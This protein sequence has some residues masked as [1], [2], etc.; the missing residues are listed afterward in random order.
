MKKFPALCLAAFIILTLNS[1]AQD[2]SVGGSGFQ[3][4]QPAAQKRTDNASAAERT[5]VPGTLYYINLKD[6]ETP[7]LKGLKLIGNR[8][9]L[10]SDSLGATVNA[11]DYS[12]DNIR[13][14]FELNEWIE[15]WPNREDAP[16][17]FQIFAVKHS[18]DR[19]VYSKMSFAALTDSSLAGTEL[20]K[21]GEEA[22]GSFYINPEDGKPGYYDLIFTENKK[23]TACITV[24]FFAEGQ[25]E[26]KSDSELESLMSAEISAAKA[27]AQP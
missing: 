13:S 20:A 9:G 3:T 8:A 14:V 22:W 4:A 1:F 5:T 18:E 15:V 12:A 24:R 6:G 7:R 2:N 26:G 23:I 21:N 17:S 25:I 10:A 16:N 19:S 27:T 11:R